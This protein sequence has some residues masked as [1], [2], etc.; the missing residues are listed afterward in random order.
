VPATFSA[1]KR[2][3]VRAYQAAREGRAV[4]LEPVPV[5]VL[6]L[7]LLAFDPPFATID[8][9]CSSGTYVRALARDVGATLGSGAHLTA[10]RRTGIGKHDVA[11]ALSVD[12]LADASKVAAALIP[13]AAALEGMPHVVID[14]EDVERIR[15]GQFLDHTQPAGTVALITGDELVAIAEADGRLIRPRKVFV[16]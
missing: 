11:D 10:L 16:A 2:D 4:H 15:H 5:R 8:V 3:G 6:A 12:A 7:E 1:K 14:D 9:S 13:T